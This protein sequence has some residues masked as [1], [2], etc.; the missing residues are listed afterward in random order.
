M[1]GLGQN[2]ASRTYLQMGENTIEVI[3]TISDLPASRK[4][5]I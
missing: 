5:T 4:G 3:S 1:Q 2:T